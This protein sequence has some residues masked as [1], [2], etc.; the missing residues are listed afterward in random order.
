MEGDG[1]VGGREELEAAA[2]EPRDARVVKELLRSMGLGDTEYEPRVVHQFLELAYR[3]VVDV[4]SDA[5]IYSDHASKT[6]IDPDDV[7]LAIQSKVN[8]SFSQP[9]PREVLLELA[10]SRNKTPLP[11]S[12]A[13]PGSIPLPPEQDTLISPNYQLLI[14]RKHPPQVEETEEDVDGSNANPVATTNLSQEPR[15]SADQQPQ[16]QSPQRVSFPLSSAAKRPRLCY[17]SELLLPWSPHY[18]QTVSILWRDERAGS[19]WIPSEGKRTERRSE[20]PESR[21]FIKHLIPVVS[22]DANGIMLLR[23]W[24]GLRGKPK[25]EI[26]VERRE[27]RATIHGHETDDGLIEAMV[28]RRYFPVR[29]PRRQRSSRGFRWRLIGVPRGRGLDLVEGK[30]RGVGVGGEMVGEVE[31]GGGA[32]E[33]EGGCVEGPGR[34]LGGVVGAEPDPLPAPRQPDL[35]NPFPPP[36]LPHPQVPALLLRRLTATGLHA[37]VLYSFAREVEYLRDA[38]GREATAWTTESAEGGW[39]RRLQTVILVGLAL[40]PAF[41]G[42]VSPKYPSNNRKYNVS[43]TEVVRFDDKEGSTLYTLFLNSA[44]EKGLHALHALFEFNLCPLIESA[45][46]ATPT[47]LVRYARRE[48]VVPDKRA[49]GKMAAEESRRQWPEIMER[50]FAGLFDPSAV[51]FLRFYSSC[52]Q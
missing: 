5:Q 30:R 36:P 50:R 12:L 21:E 27:V 1:G 37:R 32:A 28:L 14:P 6:A 35:R 52:R 4:L 38:C 2:A 15:I 40:C 23:R 7:R 45:L 33:D 49:L 20:A 51:D 25:E 46:M 29:R 26:L 31:A 11:K 48:H 43:I 39:R 13:P 3:Y 24:L 9:P 42:D 8:F 44:Q 34:L 18:E 10:R 16:Q 19:V 17:V 47:A 22:V 41:D